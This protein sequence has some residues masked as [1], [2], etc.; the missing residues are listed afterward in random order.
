MT[1]L[2]ATVRDNDA[3][4]R[5]ELLVEDEVVGELIYRARDDV[6]TLIHTE[7]APQSRVTGSANS[8]SHTRWTTSAPTACEWF[9]Y[10]RR[11]RVPPSPPGVRGH[12]Q[13][14]EPSPEQERGPRRVYANETIE[15]HWEPKLCID[16]RNCVR[17]LPQVFDPDARPWVI[18]DAASA[19][20][21]AVAVLTC[22]TG[23]LHFD[24][25]TMDRRRPR[26][27]LPPSSRGRTARCSSRTHA[28]RR[29]GRTTHPRGHARRALPLR[30]VR[31]KPFCDGSHRR[32]GFGTNA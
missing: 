14:S 13:V 22:P 15:V 32:I 2:A 3:A 25:S 26:R 17:S 24:A 10:A 16:T 28:D 23:A 21:V 30:R 6:V 18:V 29:S 31:N 27:N 19:D 20:H 11:R 8:S 5:Y 9:R 7:I 1:A 12:R 4:H